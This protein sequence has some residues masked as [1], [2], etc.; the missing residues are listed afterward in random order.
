MSTLIAVLLIVLPMVE[1]PHGVP[2]HPGPAGETGPFAL[3][4]RVRIDRG[5]ELRARGVR[6]TDEA[7][8]AEQLRWLARNLKAAG[9]DANAYNLALAWNCGLERVLQGK[10]P[11]RSYDFA[12]RVQN[13][14]ELQLELKREL[15]PRSALLGGRGLSVVL[16]S[17]NNGK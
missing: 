12:H 14:V 5:R 2:A 6:V 4:P 17:Q 11:M 16:A 3:T 9:V 8:A 13:L 15:A 7:I 10:A 1:T